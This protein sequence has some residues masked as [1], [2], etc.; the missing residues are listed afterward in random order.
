ML[1]ALSLLLLST[2]STRDAQAAVEEQEDHRGRKDKDDTY[3]DQ[4][5]Y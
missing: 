5:V 4:A 3:A 1:L 2:L